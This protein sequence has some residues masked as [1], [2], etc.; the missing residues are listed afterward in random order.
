MWCNYTKKSHI[1]CHSTQVKKVHRYVLLKGQN[2]IDKSLYLPEKK[3]NS[4]QFLLW[5]RNRRGF[6]QIMIT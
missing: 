2:Q 3:N 6:V 1:V 4:F 5:V